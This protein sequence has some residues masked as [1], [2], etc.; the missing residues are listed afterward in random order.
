M[1]LLDFLKRAKSSPSFKPA[2]IRIKPS[3]IDDPEFINESF[4]TNEQ[5]FDV[6]IN[7]MYLS[8]KREW[9]TV[10]DPMVFVITEFEY[11]GKKSPLPSIVGPSMITDK[12]LKLPAGQGFLFKNTTVAGVHPIKGNSIAITLILSRMPRSNPLRKTLGVLEGFSKTYLAE[13]NSIASGYLKVANA[14]L[15][16]IDVI[17][18]SDDVSPVIGIRDEYAYEDLKPGYFALINEESQQFNPDMF[19]VKGKELWYGENAALAKPFRSDDYVLYSLNAR[20]RRNDIE[21]LSIFSRWKEMNQSIAKAGKL[22]EKDKKFYSGQLY[23]LGSD[24]MFSPDITFTQYE[25]LLAK[26]T[27]LLNDKFERSDLLSGDTKTL[28]PVKDDWKNA[29]QEMSKE[30][31]Q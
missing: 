14:V 30:L 16:G 3:N 22:E 17:T 13:F 25:E 23:M 26:Y 7:E 27:K 19:F 18:D 21:T 15:N 11:D 10:F 29:L 4:V 24:M 2:Y 12:Q 6:V 9:F 28:V 31:F 8:Y 1:G 20:P 5:Y